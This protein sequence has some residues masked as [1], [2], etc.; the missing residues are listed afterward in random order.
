MALWPA[1]PMVA[2]L[3]A[4]ILPNPSVADDE[5]PR[6]A[7]PDQVVRSVT[8]EVMRVVAQANTYFDENPE[9]Y[10]REI[11][12]ALAELVDWRGFATAVMGD[13]YSR[14]RSMDSAGR[15]NLKRQRDQFAQTLSLIHI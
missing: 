2:L 5:S 6:Q 3:C 8:K 7:G 15:K 12:Y 1:F 11:D 14:G 9:R 10:Y 13:H 4:L